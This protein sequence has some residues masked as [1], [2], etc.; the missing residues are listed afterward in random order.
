MNDLIEKS[1]QNL[2][3]K[4]L[5]TINL[6]FQNLNN[7]ITDNLG[8]EYIEEEWNL[9]NKNA[10]QY[11]DTINSLYE[12]QKLEGKYLDALDQTDSIS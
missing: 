5:N 2:Q 11:L 6:I 3:D 8:L 9:I 12:V 4:Y 10:D 1:I 7:K